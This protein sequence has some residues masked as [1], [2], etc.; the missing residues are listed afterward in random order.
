MKLDPIKLTI[1]QTDVTVKMADAEVE[2]SDDGGVE[3]KASAINVEIDNAVYQK[4]DEP[5][6]WD[7]EEIKEV[8]RNAWLEGT[9]EWPDTLDK[10]WTE[11]RF[12]K[13]AKAQRAV[14]SAIVE[15]C[16]VTAG[17]LKEDNLLDYSVGNAIYELKQQNLVKAIDRNGQGEVLVPTHVGWKE[18]ST[19]KD[20]EI[21]KA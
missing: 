4:L 7:K 21:T 14:L 17:Y 20:I 2:P 12:T 1:G 6:D 15:N 9:V 16:P 10:E 5:V 8:V 18:Y 3:F 19:Y 13:N 11:S